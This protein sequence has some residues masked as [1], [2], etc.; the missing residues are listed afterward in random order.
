MRYAPEVIDEPTP[1]P[2]CGEGEMQA[3]G[4]QDVQ[5]LWEGAGHTA[6]GNSATLYFGA[7]RP[8][9]AAKTPLH[10]EDKLPLLYGQIV[11]LA[12]DFFGDA[13]HPISDGKTPEERR[14]LF[15]SSFSTLSAWYSLASY[16]AERVVTQC[17][18][19]EFDAIK[20]ALAEG[21]QPSTAYANVDH[22]ACATRYTLGRYPLLSAWNWDHFGDH[23]IKAYTAGHAEALDQAVAA[24]R[25]TDPARRRRA[26][27]LAYA[28]NAFADHY[29]TDLF[30]TGHLRTPRKELWERSSEIGSLLAWWMHDEDCKWGLRVQDRD[31]TEWKGYG[32]K[33]LS[34][35]VNLPNRVHAEQAVQQSVNEVF[36]AFSRGQAIDPKDYAA[37]SLL[38]DLPTVRKPDDRRHISPMFVWDGQKVLR[39]N[40]L[41][42]LEDYSWTADWNATTTWLWLREHYKPKEPSYWLQPPTGRCAF[43]PNGWRSRTPTPPNWVRGKRLRYAVSFLRDHEESQPGPWSERVTLSDRFFPTLVNVPTDPTRKAQ[44]RRIWRQ[45]DDG[46]YE[47]AGQID[48]NT[49]TRYV[50][51]KP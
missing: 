33:Q 40:D 27:E 26:L 1:C 36:E 6:L 34:D 23:A 15:V 47:L 51:E 28:K 30:S 24:S 19:G 48:D 11:A 12:G 18:V 2:P 43:D 16:Q 25:I 4:L 44:G 20:K 9:P 8:E 13:R 31:G 41:N 14:K 37:L 21:R 49:T 46:E 35:T 45:F 3:T 39:R 5:P 22:T 32:D 10:V 17:M 29:L 50:D 7:N 42:N 38:P